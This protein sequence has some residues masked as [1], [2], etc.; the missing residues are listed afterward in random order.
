MNTLPSIIKN[1]ILKIIKYNYIIL[2]YIYI[3]LNFCYITMFEKL[4]KKF[5]NE[6]QKREEVILLSREI[7]RLSK[8]IISSI[9]NEKINSAK[10]FKI[11]I[12]KKVKE[13]KKKNNHTSGSYTIALQEYVEAI[14]LLEYSTTNKILNYNR[15]NCSPEEYLL[16]VCDFVGELQ[17]RAVL[18]IS[19]GDFVTISKIYKDV[20]EIYDSLLNFNFRGELRKKFDSIKYIM[21][22]MEDLILQL[23]LK[24]K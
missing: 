13:I 1:Y 7:I 9:H 8:K 17:R 6:D 24:G 4:Q 11:K 14:L 10:K 21:I 2:R 20:S 12:D 5:E 18:K 22:K 23:K 16:G 19:R 3:S 15:I